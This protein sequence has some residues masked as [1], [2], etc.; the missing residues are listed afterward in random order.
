ML[1]CCKLRQHVTL[2]LT[3]KL[4]SLAKSAETKDLR[5][6]RKNCPEDPWIHLKELITYLL[7]HKN[8][9]AH[10]SLHHNDEGF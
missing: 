9:G 4:I 7:Y 5:R 10:M 6:I 2:N 1:V 3:I 8:P